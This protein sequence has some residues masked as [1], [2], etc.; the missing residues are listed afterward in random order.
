MISINCP[1]LFVYKM[2]IGRP[3]RM[4]DYLP[5][6]YFLFNIRF[7]MLIE[8]QRR[9]CDLKINFS[10]YS[11]SARVFLAM[12]LANNNFK[13]LWILKEL[14]FTFNTYKEE[15]F[16]QNKKTNKKND[17]WKWKS[18]AE[19]RPLLLWIPARSLYL[20]WIYSV[21]P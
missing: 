4:F 19:S 10:L 15:N 18:V 20:R 12:I 2:L 13:I 7:S 8:L 9:L 21:S 6:K 17:F 16:L 3:K 14:S 5:K 1:Q 11:W